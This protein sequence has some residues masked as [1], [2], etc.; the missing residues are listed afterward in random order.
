M[1]APGLGQQTT[2]SR[3]G[4][5]GRALLV[6]CLSPFHLVPLPADDE[7][8]LAAA[9]ARAPSRREGSERVRPASS[10]TLAREQQEQGS[11]TADRAVGAET[12]TEARR[13]LPTLTSCVQTSPVIAAAAVQTAQTQVAAAVAGVHEAAAQTEAAA[14]GVGVGVQASPARHSQAVQ[15]G[16]R[17]QQRH[18]LL[19]CQINRHVSA[20]V[21]CE[22][23]PPAG[24]DTS[25]QAQ[26]TSPAGVC[27]ALPP[28]ARVG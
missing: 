19:Q 27:G 20:G 13:R 4:G 8:E 26:T 17:V 7:Q 18:V 1:R 23:E 6:G 3:S 11:G 16:A 12:Q 2:A 25:L 10:Q 28:H 9:L 15:A 5:A 14:G 24:A 21:Q 22:P